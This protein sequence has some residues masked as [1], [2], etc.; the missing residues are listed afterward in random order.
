MPDPGRAGPEKYRVQ[1]P[2][3]KPSYPALPWTCPDVTML[4]LYF[5][6]R[7]EVLLDWLPRDLNRTSPAY[8]R[9]FIIDHPQS[10]V[11]PFREA[12]LALGCRF[13]MLPGT[14]VAS[15]VTDNEKVLAAGLFDRG[16]PW[17]LG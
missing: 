13:N 15:S 2:A 11:G 8:C 10:P 4:N 6:V 9:L 5:E 12:T 3:E 17:S 1:L 7:K 14:F 16:F